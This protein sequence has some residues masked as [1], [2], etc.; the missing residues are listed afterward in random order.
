MHRAVRAWVGHPPLCSAPSSCTCPIRGPVIPGTPAIHLPLAMV[1]VPSQGKEDPL[2][3]APG[4]PAVGPASVPLEP[5]FSPHA[6]STPGPQLSVWNLG[7][8]RLP[9]GSVLSCTSLSA[10]LLACASNLK[11]PSGWKVRLLPEGSW[12]AGWWLSRQR[13]HRG[14]CPVRVLSLPC[15][16]LA[17]ARVTRAFPCLFQLREH[18]E[19]LRQV[20]P[21]HR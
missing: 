10:G 5:S 20:Q 2:R 15:M 6:S 4:V 16:R 18:A 13:P 21:R 8:S 11:S 17:L 9:Q 1:A 19:A 14:A 3:P 7:R 12:P